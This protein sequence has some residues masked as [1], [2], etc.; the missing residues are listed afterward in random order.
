M[1]CVYVQKEAECKHVTK[2]AL[3]HNCYL[4]R[5]QEV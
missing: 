1:L 5:E 4:E 2:K 3:P